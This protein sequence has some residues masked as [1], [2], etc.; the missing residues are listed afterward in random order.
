MKPIDPHKAFEKTIREVARRRHVWEVF[1]DFC[2]MAALAFANVFPSP[3]REA[4]EERYRAIVKRYEPDEL[5]KIKQLLDITTEGLEGLD[6]D[7]L[8]EMFMRLEL[9]NHWVGQFF[10]P[11]PISRLLAELNIGD[12]IEEQIRARGFVRASEPACGAGGM[13]L[14]LARVLADRKI[15][16]QECLHV[17]AIDVD[18]TAAHMAYVQL[19]LHHIP[20]VVVIGDALAVTEREA[21]YTPAHHLGMWDGKLRRGYAVGS[22]KDRQAGGESTAESEVLDL[23]TLKQ[24]DLFVA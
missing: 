20:A 11:F 19:S 12:G 8:G 2:E 10:T 23:S 18:A 14:A 22:E 3:Q 17:T 24:G 21:F 13:V 6:N 4:R 16:F 15:N 1:S 7:F 5:L 9:G